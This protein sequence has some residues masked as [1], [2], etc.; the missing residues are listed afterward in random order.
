MTDLEGVAGVQNMQDWCN[1]EGRYYQKARELLTMEVNAAIEGFL[2]GGAKEFLVADGHG[3][4][5]ING[6]LLR[7]EAELSRNWPKGKKGFSMAQKDFDLAA[8]IGQHPMA[9]TVGGHLCHTGN[10]GVVQ[11]TIND[12]E[13]GEF[14]DLVMLAGEL[15]IRTVL[16]SGC[17]AMCREAAAFVPGIEAVAVKRGIQPEPGNHLPANAYRLHN[18]GAIHLHPREARARIRSG[19]LRA[20]TRAAGEDFGLVKP[21]APPYTRIRISRGDG[22]HPP[23]LRV[24]KH[25]ESLLGLANAPM[26]SFELKINPADPALREL[27]GDQAS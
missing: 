12:I 1:S 24:W 20:I 6:E 2:E 14:G 11:Q 13:V 22:E 15:G 19:A 7:P 25:P 26:V 9:G 3:S 27:V 8:F 10:M 17:E 5:A 18:T 4:G 21:P 16:T 23:M